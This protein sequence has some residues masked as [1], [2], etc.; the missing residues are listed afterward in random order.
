MR[1]LE[2]ERDEAFLTQMEAFIKSVVGN[3]Y[4]I[5]MRHVLFRKKS[6]DKNSSQNE[7]RRFFCSELIAKAFKEVGLLQSEQASCQFMPSDFSKEGGKLKLRG[8]ARLGDELM[9]VFDEDDIKAKRAQLK[10]EEAEQSR[11]EAEDRFRQV[12]V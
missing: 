7:E 2:C 5:S 4:N 12:E 3:S 6:F 9:I 1:H 10:R 11:K 8:E